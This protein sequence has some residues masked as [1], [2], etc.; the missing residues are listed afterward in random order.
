LGGETGLRRFDILVDGE[1]VAEES[2]HLDRPGEFVDR[3]Y[4]V[5]QAL[6]DGK[7]TIDIRFQAH[8]GNIAGGIF[9]LRVD[10]AE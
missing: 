1:K 9:G 7:S 4:P 2:L 8:P 6:L 3:S 5:P 10:K